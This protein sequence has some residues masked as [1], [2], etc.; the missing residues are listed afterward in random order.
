MA[1]WLAG[2]LAGPGVAG[3]AEEPGPPSAPG[4]PGGDAGVCDWA[5]RAGSGGIPAY[6]PCFEVELAADVTGLPPLTFTWTLPG[7]AVLTGNPVTVDTGLLSE[8]FQEIRLRV[9]GPA[10]VVEHPVHLVVESLGFSGAPSLT[11]LGD[12]RVEMRANTTGATEWRWSWGDGSGTGWLSGCAGY[13]PNHAYPG[14]GFYEVTVEARSCRGGPVSWSGLLEVRDT[15]APSI[16]RFRVV[17][18]TTPFCTFEVGEVVPF[19]VEASGVVAVYA[20]DWDGDGVDDELAGAPVTEH[21]YERAGFF[22][23]RLTVIGVGAADL[24]ILEAPVAIVEGSGGD[25]IFSDGFESG[26]LSRW[27]VP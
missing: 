21:R 17:C 8:G 7:G 2:V 5:A 20:Y 24:A 26:D 6:P 27:T 12:G 13:A 22:L 11:T 15:A 25:A 14:P 23:P 18:A 10:G 3:P 16:E 1:G 9:S 4:S 19:E